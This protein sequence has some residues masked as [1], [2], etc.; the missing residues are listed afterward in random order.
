MFIKE[1]CQ[2]KQQTTNVCGT[3]SRRRRTQKHSGI[4]C[5]I[6]WIDEIVRIPAISRNKRHSH[7]REEEPCSNRPDITVLLKPFRYARFEQ[8]QL[9]HQMSQLCADMFAH[10]AKD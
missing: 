2:K 1:Y 6:N 4:T 5:K 8:V 9:K 10:A 3:P 7:S